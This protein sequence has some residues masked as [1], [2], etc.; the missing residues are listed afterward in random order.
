MLGHHERYDGTGYPRG[1]KG[2]EIPLQARILCVADSFD[3]MMTKRSYKDPYPLDYAISQLDQC[4]GKQFDPV[5]AR[6]FI[7]LLRDGTVEIKPGSFE[8]KS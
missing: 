7:G 6:V 2:E 3:A 5:L 4:A 1:L 8:E